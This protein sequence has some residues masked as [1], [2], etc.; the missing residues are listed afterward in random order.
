[1]TNAVVAAAAAA[2]RA[3]ELQRALVARKYAKMEKTRKKERKKRTERWPKRIKFCLSLGWQLY[4]D[5]G[6]SN[7]ARIS[8]QHCHHDD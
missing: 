2:A 3:K 8:R 5:S 1:M 7:A 6:S 4:V